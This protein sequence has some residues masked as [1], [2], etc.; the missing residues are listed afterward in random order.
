MRILLAVLLVMCATLSAAVALAQTAAQF[1]A[2]ALEIEASQ[3]LEWLS[4]ENAYVARGNAKMRQGELEVSA[5]TLTANYRE[6]ADGKTEVWRVVAD[7]DV[8]IATPTQRALGD[9]GVYDIAT[10]VFTLTGSDLRLETETET[11][12]ARDSIEYWKTD[13]VAV[14]RGNARAMRGTDQIDADELKAQ[15]EEDAGGELTIRNLAA[16]GNVV[17]TTP[18]DV[19]RGDRGVFDRESNTATLSGSV[20]LTRGQNQLN[21]DY[22]EVNLSTGVSRL[23]AQPGETGRVQGLFV[24][25]PAQ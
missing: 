15:L 11:I 18:T 19:A 20:R 12:T 2:Q 16:V 13:Q 4:G 9:R 10:D 21:G 23:L 14:A 5:D 1:S 25:E 22:A 8:V 17:I 3:S 24:P 7:G 6:L